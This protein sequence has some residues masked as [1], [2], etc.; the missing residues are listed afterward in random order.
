MENN[1]FDGVFKFTN[2]SKE[3]FSVMW[4][5]KEYTFPAESTCPLI[6]PGETLENIQNI[7]KR[8]ALKYAQRE[9]AKSPEGIKLAKEG[10]KHFSPAT[11]NESILEKYIETCLN[12]LPIAQA[13]VKE[14]KKSK[15]K[16]VDNGTAIIGEGQSLQSVSKEF[17]EYVPPELGKMS[18]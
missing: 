2:A 15:T 12:P 11:Y 6:I 14:I 4:N 1:N 9:L 10:A 17:D 16:F 5:S 7:R 18:E 3:D 8:F 13:T